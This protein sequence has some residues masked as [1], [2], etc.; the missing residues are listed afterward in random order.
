MYHAAEPVLRKEQN[1]EKICA[2][3]AVQ[4]TLTV[5][6]TTS[7]TSE[8]AMAPASTSVHLAMKHVLRDMPCVMTFALLKTI[9]TQTTG[10][11]KARDN[12]SGIGKNVMEPVARDINFVAMKGASLTQTGGNV[13]SRDNASEHLNNVMKP[14]PMEEQH[15]ETTC[16]SAKME[17]VQG[18]ITP[19]TGEN[20]M[21]PANTIGSPVA[22]LVP[23]DGISA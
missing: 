13:D 19:T 18:V 2:S 17:I 7:T 9:L 1:V 23:L 14:A 4:M 10:F 15:V 6:S 16:A 11:V 20:V 21:A 22:H 3:A 12:A 8:I 5:S